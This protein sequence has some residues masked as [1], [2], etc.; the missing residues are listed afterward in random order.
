MRLLR[1]DS[2]L[3]SACDVLS[4]RFKARLLVEEG[5]R[6]YCKGGMAYVQELIAGFEDKAINQA[7]LWVRG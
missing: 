1:L 2:V 5:G 4:A 3:K 6:V 7:Y